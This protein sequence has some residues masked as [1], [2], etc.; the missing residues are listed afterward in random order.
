VVD[1]DGPPFRYER[2]K[3]G[4]GRSVSILIAR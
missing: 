4:H 3:E 1:A 2:D